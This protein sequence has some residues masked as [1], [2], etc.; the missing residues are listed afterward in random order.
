MTIP[1][2]Y[3]ELMQNQNEIIDFLSDT[4][5]KQFQQWEKELNE[6]K[7]QVNVHSPARK[8]PSTD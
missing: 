2:I 7:I 6:A 8:I 4:H 5:P 1:N 3:K